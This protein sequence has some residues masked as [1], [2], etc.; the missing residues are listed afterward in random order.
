M[1]RVRFTES[2]EREIDLA[3]SHGMKNNR[4][5]WEAASWTTYWMQEIASQHFHALGPN[6]AM[7]CV[8]SRV[9]TFPM[10]SSTSPQR[11]KSSSL[12]W[13]TCIEVRS[14]GSR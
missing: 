10:V 3:W 14:S 12:D 7:A 6:S 1:N 8:V 5:A 2:A 11:M 9:V 13:G 4:L